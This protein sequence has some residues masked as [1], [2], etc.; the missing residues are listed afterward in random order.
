VP[1]EKTRK[2]QRRRRR[3]PLGTTHLEASVP[4]LC[5]GNKI[6]KG[7]ASSLP[8][9]V[10]RRVN[11]AGG[12]ITI[13]A[14]LRTAVL[15]APHFQALSYAGGTITSGNAPFGYVGTTG[16]PNGVTDGLASFEPHQHQ[17][18]WGKKIYEFF[19]A[20][21]TRFYLHLLLYLVFLLMFVC[22]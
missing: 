18:S 2:R 5:R 15:N 7:S 17:L 1:E 16:D 11:S 20:P 6:R 12:N 19:S 13:T 4:D 21:V 10:S 14:P 22:Y 8:E 9:A 3:S